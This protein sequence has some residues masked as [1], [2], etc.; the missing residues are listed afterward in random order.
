MSQVGL[1]EAEIDSG[2]ARLPAGLV[3]V[4]A[5]VVEICAR[6]L[7]HG[8]A[9]RI[10]PLRSFRTRCSRRQALQVSSAG[11]TLELILRAVRVDVL[12]V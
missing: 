5:V 10:I 4:G 3:A 7:R 9:C 11:P 6:P 1:R 12:A 2:V 8:S